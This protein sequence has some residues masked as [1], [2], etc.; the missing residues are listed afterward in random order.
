MTA[1]TETTIRARITRAGMRALFNAQSNGLDLKLTH[2]AIGRAGA[3]FGPAGGAGGYVPTGLEAAL[4]TEFARA[5]IGGGDYLGD[6]EIVISALIDGA[7]QSWVHEVGIFADDGTLFAVWSE[8][9]NPLAYKSPNQTFLVSLTLAVTEIPPDSLTI[10]VGAPNVNLTI[11]N[12]LAQTQIAIMRI[13]R[14]ITQSEVDR[15]RPV[16]QSTWS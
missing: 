8:V 2:I 7:A 6:Y 3:Y 14:R 13:L 5:E 11:V 12:P 4:Q 1:N 10:I 16:I 9:N 15:L